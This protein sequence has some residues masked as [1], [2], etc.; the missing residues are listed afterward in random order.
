MAEFQTSVQKLLAVLRGGGKLEL[1]PYQAVPAWVNCGALSGLKVKENLTM[2]K[3]E[4]DNAD[5]DENNVSAQDLDLEAT[6]HEYLNGA[7]WD[8][9][10]GG[11]DKKTV[12]PGTTVTGA[13]FVVPSGFTFSKGY[14]IPFK[15]ADGSAPTITAA[16]GTTDGALTA[17]DDYLLQPNGDGT[18]N[19][20]PLDNAGASSSLSTTAQTLTFTITYTPAAEVTY[21]SGSKTEIPYVMARITTKNDGVPFYFT[22]YKGMISGGNE[23]SYPKDSDADRRVKCPIKLKFMSDPLY[24]ADTNG[25]GFIYELKGGYV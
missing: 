1:S 20:V 16:T 24:H 25:N 15:N 3:E 18:W 14:L 21:Q 13:S 7:V 10:R 5:A 6:L 4:N 22:G 11:F 17:D 12:T 9:L 2:G 8:I 19:I 23:F